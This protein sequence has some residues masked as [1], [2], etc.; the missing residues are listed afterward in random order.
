MAGAVKVFNESYQVAGSW[1]LGPQRPTWANFCPNL[2]VLE[3][4]EVSRLPHLVTQPAPAPPVCF[5]GAWPL[6]TI[7]IWSSKTDQL[8]ASALRA[9]GYL[10]RNFED[11]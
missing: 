9:L 10:S 5:C 3:S 11:E 8:V 6:L 2:S 7:V 4:G 1:G